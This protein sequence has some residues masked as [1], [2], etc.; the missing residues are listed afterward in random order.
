MSDDVADLRARVGRLEAIV[1]ELERRLREH[2]H[3]LT[4][5][6]S[7]TGI[8]DPDWGNYGYTANGYASDDP[9]P[10]DWKESLT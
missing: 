8:S 1:V 2:R 4:G 6:D 5:Y 10:E 9:W 7:I 3:E